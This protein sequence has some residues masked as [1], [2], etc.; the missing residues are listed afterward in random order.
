MSLILGLST[1]KVWWQICMTGSTPHRWSYLCKHL[2]RTEHALV[3]ES[4]SSNSLCSLSKR[5]SYSLWRGSS[6]SKSLES[7]TVCEWQIW[8]IG[9]YPV[10]PKNVLCSA[11]VR[12]LP[13]NAR[14][15]ALCR[16]QKMVWLQLVGLSLLITLFFMILVLAIAVYISVVV[17]YMINFPGA[18]VDLKQNNFRVLKR[19]EP[20][21]RTYK[22]SPCGIKKQIGCAQPALK[23]NSLVVNISWMRHQKHLHGQLLYKLTPIG[24]VEAQKHSKFRSLKYL[25]KWWPD[26]S[27]SIYYS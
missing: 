5:R 1:P 22:G 15:V 4:S 19:H 17:F 26:F 2:A 10:R 6:S 8:C 14:K 11:C 12:R 9:A 3:L 25:A 7:G 18:Y 23:L 21:T 24:T 20:Q 27:I 13:H 16:W